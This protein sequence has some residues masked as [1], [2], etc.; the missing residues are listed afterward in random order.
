MESKE[1]GR[2]WP[3]TFEHMEFAGMVADGA[4]AKAVGVK[5]A[6]EELDVAEVV[7]EEPIGEQTAN[8]FRLIVS[9][10]PLPADEAMVRKG[11]GKCGAIVDLKLFTDRRTGQCKG[12]ALITMADEIGFKTALKH[13]GEDC[14]GRALSVKK[15]EPAEYMDD[16]E[17]AWRSWGHR[18][19]L[20]PV[21]DDASDDEGDGREG[22]EEDQ[23]DDLQDQEDSEGD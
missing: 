12:I 21:G 17:G 14:G 6:S 7:E 13:D 23:E 1:K 20:V 15:A 11:F 2:R 10:L 9:Q 19:E 3:S 22:D 18:G 4:A 8:P 16:A 5:L